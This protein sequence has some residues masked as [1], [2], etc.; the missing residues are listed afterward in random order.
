MKG[1]QYWALSSTMA[2]FVFPIAGEGEERGI[3]G[4]ILGGTSVSD[5]MT[6]LSVTV[7]VFLFLGLLEYEYD[8]LSC[9]VCWWKG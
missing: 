8:R 6:S 2:I 1:M 9:V 4:Y 3:V 5:E 7:S